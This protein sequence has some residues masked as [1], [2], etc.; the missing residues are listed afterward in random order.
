VKKKRV[1]LIYVCTVMNI[2]AICVYVNISLANNYIKG[3]QNAKFIYFNN[4]TIMHIANSNSSPWYSWN[5]AESG[6][7][8]QNAN[9]SSP[10]YSYNK[11]AKKNRVSLIYVCTVM[12]ICAICDYVNISLANNYDIAEILLKVALSTKILIHFQF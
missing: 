7:K 12:N 1:S 3:T 6:V 2:C 10:D 8:H 5:I 4:A 9:Y 11:L